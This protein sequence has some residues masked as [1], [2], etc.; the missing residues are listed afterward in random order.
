[1]LP[2]YNFSL[3]QYQFLDAKG[4]ELDVHDKMEME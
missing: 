3:L 2:N 1:V 4:N